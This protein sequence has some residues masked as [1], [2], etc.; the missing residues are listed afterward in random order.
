VA[1]AA[2]VEAGAAKT[3]LTFTMSKPV[4]PRAFLMER[5]DRVIIDLPE[6]N[7]QLPAEAGRKR[8]GLVASFRTGLFAP[9]RSRIVI[10]LAQP[11]VVSRAEASKRDDGAASLTVELARVDREA[12]RR[13]AKADEA[14]L[15]AAAAR[16]EP[17]TTGSL[18][19]GRPLIVIDPGHGG[20]DPGAMPTAEIHEKDIVFAFAQRLR[21]RLEAGGRYRLMMTRD[22][23]VFV[24]LDERVRIA[25][26]AK[27]DLMISIHADSISRAP[28]VRGMTVYTGAERAT[29]AESARL[30][31]RENK[32]DAAGGVY[33]GD[34]ASDVADIL[35]ELTQ[36]E[37]RGLSHRFARRLL[38]H[39][40]AVIPANKKPHREAGFRV[41]RA[42][43]V[44]SVLVELGYLSSRKDIGLLTSDAWRDR[45]AGAMAEAVDRFFSARMAGGGGGA[46]R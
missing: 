44:P 22:E 12:F 3:R 7:F 8:E 17:A 34:A 1:I 32:A 43:D 38:G 28:H 27:A 9:G 5:P 14:A 42:P 19:D 41:L 15:A 16:P 21:A 36:R 40:A 26:A 37:T 13:A 24:P 33:P 23:D 31:E 30:A 35:Q 25:R 4:E 20:I 18:G 45:S 10:D 46:V 29:D 11:A 39:L 6:V 2:E